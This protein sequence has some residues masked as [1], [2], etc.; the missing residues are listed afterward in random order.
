MPAPMI[1]TRGVTKCF[2]GK[3]ALTD[4]DLSIGQGRVLALLGPNG[5]GKTTLVKVLTTLLRPDEGSATV[6]G[7]D[8][9]TEA[10][11]LRSHIGLAGQY[12][13]VDELLTGRENLELVGLLYHLGRAERRRRAQEV[14]ERFALTDAAD[15]QVRTYSGGMRRRLDVGACLVARPPVLFLDEPTTGLDPR[16]RNHLWQ[17]V[18]DLVAEG[19]TVLLTTQHMEE[20]EALAHH[21]AVL[22][23]GRVIAQGTADELKSQVGGD[24]LEARVVDRGD[25]ERA[26]AI[27][28]E[29]GAGPAQV[30]AEERR[31]SVPTGGGTKALI[32]AGQHLSQGR[33]DLQD[34]GLRRPSLD[35]VFLTFT[36]GAPD[37]PPDAAPS[38]DGETPGPDRPPSGGPGGPGGR[39]PGGPGAGN[40]GPGGPGAEGGS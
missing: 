22:N 1:E 17:F 16:T 21:I 18:R 35:D 31:V 24:V 7:C 4:I 27:L 6:A 29:V 2:K 9:A 11:R 3:R 34:L 39:G 23:E 32:A 8:V 33:I 30:A 13:A 10:V 36:G 5:A 15:H 20:A 37:E 40:P 26:R 12:A 25:L 28:D 38:S 14:L 19:T